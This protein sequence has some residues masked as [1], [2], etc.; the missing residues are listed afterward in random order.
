MHAKDKKARRTRGDTTA[1]EEHWY[2]VMRSR[3]LERAAA[4]E[5][6][7]ARND[8]ARND[9]ARPKKDAVLEGEDGPI[10]PAR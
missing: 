9:E 4:D 6:D 7:E 1:Y 5:A 2:Q 3:A 8:K 10:I